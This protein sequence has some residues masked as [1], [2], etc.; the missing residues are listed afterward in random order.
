MEKDKS[1]DIGT[2]QAH[3]LSCHKLLYMYKMFA[4]FQSVMQ[5]IHGHDTLQHAHYPKP[6]WDSLEP[7]HKF[8]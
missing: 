5:L 4:S 1:N 6:T 7:Q 8:R 2:E 3:I